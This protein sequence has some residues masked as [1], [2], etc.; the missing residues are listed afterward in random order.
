MLNEIRERMVRTGE[1]L[2][3]PTVYKPKAQKTRRKAVRSEKEIAGEFYD[4]DDEWNDW[5][6][7]EHC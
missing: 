1:A 2:N 4:D 7:R 3:Q 5:P 6:E